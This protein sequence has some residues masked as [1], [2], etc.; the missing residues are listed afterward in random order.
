MA[1]TGP[2][3]VQL[4]AKSLRLPVS[5]VRNFDRKLMEA[6]LRSKRGHGRGGA[7][8]TP[9]DAAMLLLG[10]AASDEVNQVVDCVL[11]ACDL[12]ILRKA[13]V[14][15]ERF[16]KDQEIDEIARLLNCDRAAIETLGS[17]LANAMACLARGP[18]SLQVT[19]EVD[20]V[21]GRPLGAEL[22]FTDDATDRLTLLKFR[23]T[24]TVNQYLQSALRVVRFIPGSAISHIV[25]QV[26]PSSGSEGEI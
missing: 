7:L 2:A 14:G 20:S 21:G 25:G 11:V 8:M 18:S 12:P 22:F 26:S 23:A 9:R 19:L 6:G 15:H 4:T 17:A 3:L 10:L 1:L 16:T 5:T 13:E 24:G